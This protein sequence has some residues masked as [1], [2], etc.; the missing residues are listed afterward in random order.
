MKK[1]E[2]STALGISTGLLSTIVSDL[3]ADR[4]LRII[5][6]VSIMSGVCTFFLFYDSGNKKKKAV[7][8][9]CAVLSAVILVTA[10]FGNGVSAGDVIWHV[11]NF[12]KARPGAQDEY[13]KLYQET[14]DANQEL[15]EFIETVNYDSMSKN[16]KKI[17]T[18]AAKLAESIH[19]EQSLKDKEDQKEIAA[20]LLLIQ[21]H[22]DA[23]YDNG[24]LA[25]PDLKTDKEM[26][27]FFYKMR[28]SEDTCEYYYCNILKAMEGYGIDCEGFEIDEFTLAHWDT[29]I[30]FM[31]Y[32][33]RKSLVMEQ[34]ENDE[35]EKDWPQFNDYKITIGEY[36]DSLDYKN[37]Y[38][39]FPDRKLSDMIKFRDD[40]ILKYYNKF[41]RNFERL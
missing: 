7:P 30:L 36:S 39:Q 2:L 34:G 14:V 15:E 23:A 40:S 18:D 10:F 27:E 22:S 16:L 13:E 6:V 29:D 11:G 32:N 21:E 35:Y 3:I 8:G 24:S 4:I 5:F 37:W 12:F 17:E 1:E 26:V 19:R 38:I 31:D 25:F 9:V 41:K 33:M 20:I 28:L